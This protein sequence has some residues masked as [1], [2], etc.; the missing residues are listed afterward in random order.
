MIKDQVTLEKVLFEER[1]DINQHKDNL[2]VDEA[3]RVILN[4]IIVDVINKSEKKFTETLDTLVLN[5]NRREDYK[6]SNYSLLAL[7]TPSEILYNGIT[8]IVTS[9][10]KKDKKFITYQ[11]LATG[12]GTSIN[13]L[14]VGVQ[15]TAPDTASYIKKVRETAK[16]K[17]SSEAY[18]QKVIKFWS[19]RNEIVT[20]NLP[21]SA[22]LSLGHLVLSHI[23]EYTDL[24][25]M[26]SKQGL[27][28]SLSLSEHYVE[29]LYALAQ[30][31]AET[32]HNFYPM[33]E[34]PK[35]WKGFYGNP[36]YT[37]QKHNNLSL[38]KVKK[39]AF[40]DE[41]SF[42]EYTKQDFGEARVAVN[43][44]QSV[45]YQF[46]TQVIEVIKECIKLNLLPSE[47]GDFVEY[48]TTSKFHLDTPKEEMSSAE[49][50]EFKEW[51]INRRDNYLKDRQRRSKL[52]GIRSA[53]STYE[54]LKEYDELYFPA[55]LD[56]RGRI[57]YI[58][59]TIN[60]QLKSPIKAML[61]FKNGKA[62]G[63]RGF[64]W[65]CVHGANK[66]GNDKV[67]YDDRYQWILDNK[68]DWYT[69]VSDPI[70]NKHLW[71]DSDKPLEFLAF[72]F[73]FV[74]AFQD[75]ENFI[76][77]LP[78]S[79]DG[80][81]N[82]LQ[83][84]SA[85]LRDTESATNTNLVP[86]KV[87]ADIY[88]NIA[89][90]LQTYLLNDKDSDMFSISDYIINTL[91]DSKISRK[92]VKRPVMTLPYGVTPQTTLQHLQG[93][94]KEDNK[95]YDFL[96]GIDKFN[97]YVR[98]LN[99]SLWT[100]L[101]SSVRSATETMSYLSNNT[102]RTVKESREAMSWTTPAGFPVYQ[103]AHTLDK[104]N[105]KT[106]KLGYG[107]VKVLR[108]LPS[109]EVNVSKQKQ[110]ISPNLI[111][112]LDASHLQLTT[113]DLIKKGITDFVFIH[114][115][116]GCHAGNTEELQ[117]SIR[118][119]FVDMYQNYCPLINLASKYN[120]NLEE[121]TFGDLDIEVVKKSPYFFG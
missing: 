50:K 90:D 21:N 114:D 13:N 8:T 98:Y 14:L 102:A 67:S 15:I 63:K 20:D 62:L 121:I 26:T 60:P 78:V 3:L 120:W 79:L 36:Y 84:F 93:D 24:L 113:L 11:T 116:F 55:K 112:S 19:N 43:H 10:Y 83:H 105:R 70:S 39:I 117:E 59:T 47:L 87:P 107:R 72:C 42:E 35:E 16:K 89:N 18:I 73:E 5:Y 2:Y 49:L 65:L 71:V 52:W 96:K 17:G 103:Q 30:Y 37:K 97:E 64:Y 86:G 115:D 41:E 48:D 68:D 57:Y 53:L 29:R 28:H 88:Q 4:K 104:N 77:Y 92:L 56:F 54:R 108:I 7:L 66:Y 82:G 61:K 69:I 106:L 32:N 27:A 46:N 94:L 99:K 75:Q 118:R 44:I 34:P 25:V 101:N 95:V 40:S 51:K 6:I 119:V 45:P 85:I 110:G 22:K 100:T 91:W 58:P 81:C 33:I 74:D 111:H 23:L 12:I 76:S 80:S 109:L 1:M 9:F 38:V 31:F